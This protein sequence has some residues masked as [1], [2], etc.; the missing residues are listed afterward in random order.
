MRWVKSGPTT[1][2]SGLYSG[3]AY[4]LSSRTTPSAL[5]GVL[6]LES[7]EVDLRVGVGGGERCIIHMH[8]YKCT[9]TTETTYSMKDTH[10]QSL[11]A[12]FAVPPNK[13]NI[14]EDYR[15]P[16]PLP[17][18]KYSSKPQNVTRNKQKMH[19]HH[20]L[21]LRRYIYR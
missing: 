5:S 6:G 14:I 15:P 20:T 1:T 12:T 18:N 7:D 17:R 4:S 19:H 13:P 21:N 3:N 8:V 9:S 11:Y 10:K 2:N 16:P